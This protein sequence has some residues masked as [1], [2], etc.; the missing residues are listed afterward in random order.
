MNY[1]IASPLFNKISI[2]LDPVYYSGKIFV[3]ESPDSYKDSY[4]IQSLELNGKPYIKYTIN[5]QDIVNGGK[6]VFKLKKGVK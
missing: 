3:I 6:L 4:Y 1:Q 5:H 2:E